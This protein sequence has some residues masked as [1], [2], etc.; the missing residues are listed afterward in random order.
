MGLDQYIFRIKKAN[1]E[2]R[3]WDTNELKERGCTYAYTGADDGLSKDAPVIQYAQKLDV[4]FECYDTKK[5]IADYNLPEDSRID[6]SMLNSIRLIGHRDGETIRQEITNDE[7]KEKYTVNRVIPCYVW[8][9]D[10][11]A[12]WRKCYELQDW[13]YEN[14]E[15]AGNCEYCLLDA[16]Q[17]SIINAEC[18]ADIPEEDPTDEVGYFYWEWY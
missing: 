5:I 4:R 8:S 1:L 14:V 9:E 7:V 2:D 12:Y 17:I 6:W 15:G 10:E 11:I 18:D 13:I 3:I 16:E